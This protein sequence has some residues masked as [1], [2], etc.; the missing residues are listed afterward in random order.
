MKQAAISLDGYIARMNGAVDFLVM[1]KDMS[2]APSFATVDI[3]WPL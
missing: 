3:L 1:P 2:M